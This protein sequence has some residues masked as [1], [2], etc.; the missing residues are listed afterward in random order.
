MSYGTSAYGAA[1]YG[2]DIEAGLVGAAS[3]SINVEVGAF[4]QASLPIEVSIG[5]FGPIGQATLPISI[6]VGAFGS[7]S[8]PVRVTVGT[9]GVA[10]LPVDVLVGLLGYPEL[11]ISVNVL[12]F[13]IATLLISIGVGQFGSA[14]LSTRV[15]VVDPGVADGTETV[16]DGGAA[17]AVW[18]AIV[19]VGG[20]DVSDSVIGEIV[21]EAEEGA[22]RVADFTLYQTGAV[23]IQNWTGKPVA[24]YIADM[25]SGSPTNVMPLFSGIV[26]LPRIDTST[27][28]IALSC[29]DN[30]QGILSGLSRSQIDTL[31]GGYWSSAV[32]DKA[33]SSWVYANDRLST[34]A[35]SFDLSPTGELRL[36]PWAAK[37][38]ADLSFNNDSVLD[39]GVLPDIADR[40]S[41]VNRID[42][43]FGYRFPRLKAEGYALSFD[44]ID[45]AS[46]TF[47][48]W[49]SAGNK[50][51]VR[52]AVISAIESAGGTV[53][54]IDWMALPTTA[55]PLYGTGGAIGDIVGLWIPNPATDPSLCLGFDAVVS[56]DFTQQAEEQHRI[57][58]VNQKSID[59][60]GLMRDEM[61]GALEGVYTD[62]VAVEQNLFLYKTGVTSIPPLNLA[63]PV[64]GTTVAATPTLATDSDRAAADAAMKALI[65]VAM[66][67][68]VESHRNNTVPFNVPLNPVIDTDKTIAIAAQGIEAKG[69]VRK[70]KHRLNPDSGEAISEVQLAICSA[71]GV[72]IVHDE[73]AVVAPEGIADGTSGTLGAPVIVWNGLQLDDGELTI[74]F[75]GVEE[76]Q[77]TTDLQVFD[78]TFAAPLPEDLLTV[79]M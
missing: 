68:V 76:Y 44:F 36:T 45:A 24:I 60:V 13:G 38:V 56:F 29:T 34:V 67:K 25:S 78:S 62:T 19:T 39:G 48:A 26:D 66:T 14:S 22:A 52:D 65:A 59:A 40:G 4:G 17:A 42:I 43:D 49:V 33:A 51:L 74:T 79:T 50:F 18:G 71:V 53:F 73:D 63:S 9:I 15:S 35:A 27:S 2:S 28:S 11:P 77:R 70:L 32:F 46:S 20:V 47:S 23:T 72:G 10:T 64:A 7:D 61:S 57:A 5:V 21:I 12:P 8:L 37:E 41:L 1:A 69:K 6:E 54:S 31:V 75:P 16:A 55:Q 30:R 58:V 3:L